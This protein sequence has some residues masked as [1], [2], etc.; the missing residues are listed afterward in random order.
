MTLLAYFGAYCIVNRI[1]SVEERRRIGAA[2]IRIEA[3]I[4]THADYALIDDAKRL[5]AK[6]LKSQQL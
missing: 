4:G 5:G 3:G 1:C 2:L 6:A